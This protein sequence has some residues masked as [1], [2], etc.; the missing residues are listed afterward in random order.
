MHTISSTIIN[1]KPRRVYIQ[2]RAH[3]IL[4]FA[5]TC[6][7]FYDR[8]A[9]TLQM[10]NSLSN[11]DQWN[12]L[13]TIIAIVEFINLLPVFDDFCSLPHYV[14]YFYFNKV[15]IKKVLFNIHYNRK[16]VMTKYVSNVDA[17]WQIGLVIQNFFSRIK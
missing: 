1:V 10:D 8:A 9:P 2:S 4:L 3:N 13:F 15:C 17:T 14:R 12:I 11:I 7:L 5:S 16:I 6:H